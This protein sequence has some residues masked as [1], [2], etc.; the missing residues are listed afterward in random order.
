MSLWVS[1]RALAHNHLLD[2]PTRGW[3]ASV[4]LS[5]CV[6]AI[7]LLHLAVSCVFMNALPLHF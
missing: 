7:A 6:H 5:H 4:A 1:E 2:Q 3:L